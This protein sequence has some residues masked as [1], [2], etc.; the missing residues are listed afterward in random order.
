MHFCISMKYF[1]IWT[2]IYQQHVLVS[3]LFIPH[4]IFISCRLVSKFPSQTASQIWLLCVKELKNYPLSVRSR[5]QKM[6]L[7]AYTKG[8]EKWS[9]ECSLKDSKNDPLSVC[10]RTQ[11][12]TLWAYAQ[13]HILVEHFYLQMRQKD[14]DFLSWS[15]PVPMVTFLG[16][17]N[18]I[19][20]LAF[21]SRIMNLSINS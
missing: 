19:V 10:S 2:W 13:G 5:T 4:N 12:M 1:E 21:L 16:L 18:L 20:K 15:M 3:F 6:T 11:K 14:G 7:I 17:L 8:P 9:F